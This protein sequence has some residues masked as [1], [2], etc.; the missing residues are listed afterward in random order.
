MKKNIAKKNNAMNPN[1]DYLNI[2]QNSW[3]T[4]A[5]SNYAS[6][7]YRME[8]FLKGEN[9]LKEPELKLL[10]EVKG[11][12][13][14]HLQCHFGQDSLSLAR[15]GAKVTGIDLSTRAI[16]LAKN[17]NQQLGLDA[18]FHCTDVYH[19]LDHVEGPFETVFSSWGTIGWLPDLN[20]WA[21][22]ISGALK[23]GGRLVFAEFH[24]VIWMFDNDFKEIAYPY[25][26]SDPIV[27]ELEGNYAEKEKD[28]RGT[29]ISWNHGLSEVLQSL[30]DAGLDIQTFQE[31]DYS[32]YEIFKEMDEFEPGKYRLK[33]FGSKL[34]LCYALLARKS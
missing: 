20:K 11:Q 14:L 5:D 3:N 21:Q 23:P 1:A 32:P 30:I 22:V 7:F 25:L 13:I 4:W 31:F 34:P 33:K 27:E 17:L 26:K 15:M 8:A 19:T 12:R 18:Q 29:F 16:E 10:G 2:N 28:M 6:D 9:S 24:P